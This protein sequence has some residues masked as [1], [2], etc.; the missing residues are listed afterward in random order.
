VDDQPPD[1]ADEEPD[2][3]LHLQ[4]DAAAF[5]NHIQSPVVTRRIPALF[6]TFVNAA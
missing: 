1:E 5:L 2:Q 4:R 3:H 6:P